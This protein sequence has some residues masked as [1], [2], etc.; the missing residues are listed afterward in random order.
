MPCQELLQ[1]RL[2]KAFAARDQLGGG[3]FCRAVHGEQ[4]GLPGP[5]VI[6]IIRIRIIIAITTCLVIV[7]TIVIMFIITIGIII[8]LGTQI[9]FASDRRCHCRPLWQVCCCDFRV[10]GIC[11]AGAGGSGG[12]H[13]MDWK[14]STVDFRLHQTL[15]WRH[16][17]FRGVQLQRDTG[18]K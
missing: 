9:N 5:A 4:D 17:L 1:A 15:F 2:R 12:A 7:S 13:P 8:I 14:A 6:S 18:R 3:S 11:K 16:V 10:G